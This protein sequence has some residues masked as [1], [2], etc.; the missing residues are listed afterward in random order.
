MK[1][2]KRTDRIASEIRAALATLFLC[3]VGDPRVR[4]GVVTGVKVTAD[5][6]L[7]RVYVRSLQSD[8]QGRA[9]LLAGLDQCSSFLR[10]ELSR[11][12]RLLRTPRLEFHYDELQDQAA[13]VEELMRTLP[14]PAKDSG[15]E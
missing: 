4:L 15:Q 9:E 14:P 1:P 12:V 7:C 2:F 10:R 5:M 6:G 11:R 8:A 3:E 13:R